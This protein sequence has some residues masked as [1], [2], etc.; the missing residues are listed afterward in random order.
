[1]RINQGNNH[2]NSSTLKALTGAVVSAVAISAVVLA[3]VSGTARAATVPWSPEWV[4]VPSPSPGAASSVFRAVSAIATG[5]VWAVGESRGNTL[6]TLTAHWDGAQWTLVPSPNFGTQGS[7]LNG[8]DA[9]SANDVWAV[10]EYVIGSGTPQTLALHWSGS[11]WELVS[12]P[13]IQGGSSLNAIVA[14]SG[15]DVWAVGNRAVGAPGPTVGTL[16]IHWNGSSWNVVSSPNTGS[17]W[18]D[19]QAVSAIAPDDIWAV[20]ST[21][22]PT[23]P[24][25]ALVVHWDGSS[26]NIVPAPSGSFGTQ[27]SAVAAV[28]SN[29][30]WASGVD[31]DSGGNGHPYFLHWNGSGWQTVPSPGGVLA[32]LGCRSGLSAIAPDDVWAV[33]GTFAHWDGTGWTLVPGAPVPGTDVRPIAVDSISSTDVWAV[34]SY[35]NGSSTVTLTEHWQEQGP[36]T[37]TPIPPT[38]TATNA[39]PTTVS[40]AT[41]TATATST[42]V[43][44]TTATPTLTPTPAASA[45]S[46]ANTPTPTFTSVPSSTATA[47]STPPPTSTAC[48]ISF[49]DVPTTHP[50]YPYIRCLACRGILGGYSDGTFRPDN[51]VTRGQLAKIVAN[52]AGFSEPVSGQTF[53][54]V[55]PSH[56]FY[57]YIERMAGRG[58]IGGYSDGTFRPDNNATRGQISKIVANAAGILDPIPSNRQTFS[59]VPSTHPFWV[60]IERLAGR[61]ILGGYSDGTFR[62]DNNATR[63]QTAKIVSNAFFPECSMP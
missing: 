63:G 43:P 61:G 13:V 25:Q 38:S 56:P 53:S 59:D 9:V 33:G 51:F 62:P 31:L 16:V 3:G 60:Y 52:A 8:V 10:G 27:L 46:P 49:S 1:M 50:F 57:V 41:R 23:G 39:T 21:R 45:T 26:W 7:R 18:N 44:G 42:S 48:T 15:N 5:D 30:V 22:S 34:G 36:V 11:A 58:I 29:D 35:H 40:T 47:T 19:L 20:G 4:F 32:C 12:S 2:M 37:A 14:L 55:P 28:S 6:T 24:Y 17:R 54:D